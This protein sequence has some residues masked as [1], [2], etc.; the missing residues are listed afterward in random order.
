MVAAGNEVLSLQIGVSMECGQECFTSVINDMD[1][2]FFT[3]S[4]FLLLN[5]FGMGEG[6]T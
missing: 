4:L 6:T 1:P 3:F 5:F 2:L